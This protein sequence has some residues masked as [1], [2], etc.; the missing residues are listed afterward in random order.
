VHALAVRAGVTTTEAKR[1]KFGSKH[2]TFLSR[3]FDRAGE[4]KRIHFASAMTLLER[5][6]GEAGASYLDCLGQCIDPVAEAA[7]GPIPTLPT[8][9]VSPAEFVVPLPSSA[10]AT[11]QL[12]PQVPD[13]GTARTREV[14]IT[15][16]ARKLTQDAAGKVT[17]PFPT[18]TI[19]PDL[20][21]SPETSHLCSRKAG[22]S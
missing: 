14:T 4:N 6:D 20:Q 15:I 10:I 11:G 22:Q 17:G 9:D 1:P 5:N 18:L 16:T 3:R 8:L 7:P 21:R 19:R 13:W 2:H 12:Y